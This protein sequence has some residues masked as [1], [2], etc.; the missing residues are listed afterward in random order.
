MA[1]HNIGNQYGVLSSGKSSDKGQ[2]GGALITPGGSKKV[3]R[4]NLDDVL[5]DTNAGDTGSIN[6]NSSITDSEIDGILSKLNRKGRS[7]SRTSNKSSSNTRTRSKSTN[8]NSNPI[9]SINTSGNSRPKSA[10]PKDIVITAD[11]MAA[12][13]KRKRSKSAPL[14]SD[15]SQRKLDAFSDLDSIFMNT[16]AS[17]SLPPLQPK[18]S[19]T[20]LTINSPPPTYNAALSMPRLSTHTSQSQQYTPN[21]TQHGSPQ[22]TQPTPTTHKVDTAKIA[23]L[24]DRISKVRDQIKKIKNKIKKK[25]KANVGKKYL[26][27]LSDYERKERKYGKMLEAASKGSIDTTTTDTTPH[28]AMQNSPS[29]QPIYQSHNNVDNSN[30]PIHSNNTSNKNVDMNL[31]NGTK[32]N[33]MDMM[34][35]LDSEIANANARLSYELQQPPRPKSKLFMDGGGASPVNSILKRSTTAISNGRLS[36]LDLDKKKEQQASIY[37]MSTAINELK[38]KRRNMLEKQQKM[39]KA[40]EYKQRQIAKIKSRQEEVKRLKALEKERKRIYDMERKMKKLERYQYLQTQK[41]KEELYAVNYEDQQAKQTINNTARNYHRNDQSRKLAELESARQKRG[42]A[43]PSSVAPYLPLGSPPS[44]NADGTTKYPEGYISWFLKKLGSVKIGEQIV[45]MPTID[46]SNASGNSNSDANPNVT[47]IP[48]AESQNS[49]LSSNSQS[50]NQSNNVNKKL[51]VDD[52]VIGRSS[53]EKIV[54]SQEVARYKYYTKIP[55]G[56]QPPKK[57]NHDP[58]HNND[59]ASWTFYIFLNIY[60]TVLQQIDASDDASGDSIDDASDSGNIT[61]GNAG[62]ILE[63]DGISKRVDLGDYLDINNLDKLDMVVNNKR[64][65]ELLCILCRDC[66]VVG[67]RINRREITTHG[68]DEA[69]SLSSTPLPIDPTASPILALSDS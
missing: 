43:R 19:Y 67:G 35:D 51:E 56:L 55:D 4:M 15:E 65:L 63:G 6:G 16:A 5:G 48:K 11:E 37:S 38:Q 69:F 32:Y 54:A 12:M 39:Q 17:S 46:N 30:N 61:N 28:R 36:A 33:N 13:N 9:S 40:Y 47:P 50:N 68:I 29:K 31:R 20:P 10:V 22:I 14:I 53:G 58:T 44:K 18:R 23:D 3:I 59:E 41:L 1:L 7:S 64:K 2:P 62:D 24:R 34:T 60:D 25:G 26:D 21:Q 45:F 52:R 42:G 57:Y 8:F 66:H 49:Y 27:A